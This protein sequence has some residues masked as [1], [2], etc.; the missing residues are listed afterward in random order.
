[1]E[2]LPAIDLMKLPFHAPSGADP[3]ARQIHGKFI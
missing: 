2:A 3:G 1:M